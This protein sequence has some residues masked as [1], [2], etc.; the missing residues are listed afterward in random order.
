L[1]ELQAVAD[2]G[3]DIA[4]ITVALRSEPAR[5]AGTA[6]ANGVTT[7]PVLLGDAATRKAFGIAE[8]PATMVVGRDGR[9]VKLLMGGRERAEFQQALDAI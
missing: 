9:A 4:V 8:V 2:Q 1:P 5:A 6:R 3:G 7:M